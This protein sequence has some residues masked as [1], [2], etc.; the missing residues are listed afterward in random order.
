MGVSNFKELIKHEGHKIAVVTYGVGKKPI[1]A[2][3]ECE[4]CSE[5]LLDY[6]REV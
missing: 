2:A 6:D 5:I 3:I 1:N 4:D